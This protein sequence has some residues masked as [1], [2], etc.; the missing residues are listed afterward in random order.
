MC[1]FQNKL[2]T[3]IT[4]IV[5]SVSEELKAKCRAGVGNFC[6][7]KCRGA[8][9]SLLPEESLSLPVCDMCVSIASRMTEE[10]VITWMQNHATLCKL[11]LILYLTCSF[12]FFFSPWSFQLIALIFVLL[13]LTAL[14]SKDLQNEAEKF[15]K[16]RE[17]FETVVSAKTSHIA[18]GANASWQHDDAAPSP[19]SVLQSL[20]VSKGNIVRFHVHFKI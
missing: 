17:R 2:N 5:D 19:F 18:P 7:S 16:N 14:Y 1:L 15:I 6:W 3:E 9:M 12:F 8:L 13:I 10:R 11:F 4:D 20:K